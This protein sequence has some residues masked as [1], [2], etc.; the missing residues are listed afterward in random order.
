MNVTD[1][2]GGN[3]ELNK[4]KIGITKVVGG[5]QPWWLGSLVRQCYIQLIHVLAIGGSNP[6]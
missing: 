5:I 1:I 6:A 3:I 4:L 2:V